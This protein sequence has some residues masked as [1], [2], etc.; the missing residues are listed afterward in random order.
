MN[1]VLGAVA[2]VAVFGLLYAHFTHLSIKQL[3]AKIEGVFGGAANITPPSPALATAPAPLTALAPAGGSLLSTLPAGVIG[4]PNADL[5]VQ[6]QAA[7][8]A[9]AK[10]LHDPNPINAWWASVLPHWWGF[11]E[12]ADLYTGDAAKYLFGQCNRSMLTGALQGNNFNSKMWHVWQS[13]PSE[14]V[15]YVS[16]IDAAVVAGSNPLPSG[17][18]FPGI[19]VA[20]MVSLLEANRQMV[21]AH[22][23]VPQI[24]VAGFGR[25]GIVGP[26]HG[27]TAGK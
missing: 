3:E 5:L 19:K 7:E 18:G 9:R 4:Q 22:G 8:D 15:K 25:G 24:A 13:P 26:G 16:V 14:P 21:L 11:E 23:A 20:D 2:L 1:Y 17:L 10:Y 12:I 6:I 27:A